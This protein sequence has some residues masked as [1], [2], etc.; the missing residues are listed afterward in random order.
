MTLGIR[1]LIK[2]PNPS[3]KQDVHNSILFLRKR[4][5]FNIYPYSI[6]SHFDRPVTISDLLLTT[7][8]HLSRCNYRQLSA[9][10][11]HETVVHQLSTSPNPN[12]I[13]GGLQTSSDHYVS[14]QLVSYIFE[15]QQLWESFHTEILEILENRPTKTS[16]KDHPDIRTTLFLRL[17]VN[18]SK[19]TLY[20]VLVIRGSI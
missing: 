4:G 13:C 19:I 3:K 1:K 8:Y 10:K 12:K 7:N 17:P 11:H 9:C 18:G 16:I 2:T 5:M 14:F 15:H 20:L 6:N